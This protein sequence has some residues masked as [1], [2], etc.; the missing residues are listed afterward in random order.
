M[1]N[2]P[3]THTQQD[4][5]TLVY[6]KFWAQVTQ[7]FYERHSTETQQD[8]QSLVYAKL[9]AQLTLQCFE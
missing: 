2:T 3:L 7:Q 9:W 6:A 4:V 5:Q 8:V 1:N